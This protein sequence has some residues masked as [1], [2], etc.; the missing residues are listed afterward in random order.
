MKSV[1]WALQGG[2][3]VGALRQQ[4]TMGRKDGKWEV[5]LQSVIGKVR[6]HVHCREESKLAP[7]TGRALWAGKIGELEVFRCGTGGTGQEGSGTGRGWLRT[8]W[9]REEN[10]NDTNMQAPILKNCWRLCLC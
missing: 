9:W 2:I 1:G 4:S 8:L 10:S 5:W 3:K 7:S 6:G